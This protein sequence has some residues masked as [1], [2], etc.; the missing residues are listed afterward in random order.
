M[1][2]IDPQTRNLPAGPSLSFALGARLLGVPLYMQR[3]SADLLARAIQAREFDPHP[4]GAVTASRFIGTADGRS[5]IRVTD[6]IAL[7]PVQGVLVDRGAWLGDLNGIATSYEGLTE[8]FN[9]LADDAAIRAVVL[10]IDSPGGM[11]AGVYDLC[12]QLEKLTKAKPVF[13]L[14]ANMAASAA[15][16]IACVAKEVYVTR[17]GEAG[18]IGVAMIHQ[19]YGRM[20]DQMGIDTTIICEPEPK[21]DGNP[22]NALTHGARADMAARIELAHGIFVDHVAKH[23]RMSRDAVKA[24]QARSFSGAKAVA[25]GLADG[26]KSIHELLDHIHKTTKSGSLAQGRKAPSAPS[27]DKRAA[28]AYCL[29]AMGSDVMAMASVMEKRRKTRQGN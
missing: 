14:A 11:V 19:S 7:V 10:D 24:T 13:A 8:Q 6:G 5:K 22:F 20:L 29:R 9:R 21:A 12:A 18:S 23:R 25:A 2:I 1:A 17:T 15:Y 27:A 26:V 16:L 4:G 28:L 3:G